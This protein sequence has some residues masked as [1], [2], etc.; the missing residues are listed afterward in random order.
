MRRK[1]VAGAAIDLKSFMERAASK[2]KQTQTEN[3]CNQLV[4]F[5]GLDG[6]ESG[7]SMPVPPEPEIAAS[8]ERENEEISEGDISSD[9]DEYDDDGVYDIEP[10]P[11]LRTPISGYDV[12]SQDSVRRAYIVLGPCRP[13]MKKDDFP[14]HMCG[15]MRRFQP[16][17]FDEF[18]W[19]EY[20][21]D[22]DAAYCFVC[23]LFKGGNKFA[24]GDSFINGGF[25]NWNMKARFR[26]HAGEI[27][28]A[29]SEA[30]EKY[31]MFITPK[32]SIR[33][34]ICESCSLEMVT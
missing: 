10:D 15:G 19:L 25:R 28:S 9:S 5:Q 20:N 31:N 12:N 18:K 8:T 23:Y 34:S 33:E 32:A 3:Q 7:T 16:K 14:Q 4:I 29:H 26:K 6:S 2:K 24:G 27:N 1:I 21:I 13:K 11:G 30:E 22:K 17:W